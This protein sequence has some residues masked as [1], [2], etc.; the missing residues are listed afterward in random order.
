MSRADRQIHR[1]KASSCNLW[2]FVFV[3][4]T[5]LSPINERN[6]SDEGYHIA[7]VKRHRK[8]RWDIMELELKRGSTVLTS[9]DQQCSICLYANQIGTLAQWNE[10]MSQTTPSSQGESETRVLSAS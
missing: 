9:G 6:V 2:L 5:A 10:L 7:D 3:R 8:I 4:C 1:R